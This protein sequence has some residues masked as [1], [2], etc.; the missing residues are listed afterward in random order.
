MSSPDDHRLSNIKGV[1]Y[2]SSLNVLS[3]LLPGASLSYYGEEI[4]LL[5]MTP[6]DDTVAKYNSHL[7]QAVCCNLQICIQLTVIIFHFKLWRFL[8]LAILQF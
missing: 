5:E 1:T 3:I 4:G 6:H 2:Q 7:A 8:F